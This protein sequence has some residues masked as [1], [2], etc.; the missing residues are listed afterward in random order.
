MALLKP[1]V[2]FWVLPCACQNPNF[3]SIWWLC[4]GT[5]KGPFSKN[6][7]SQRQCAFCFT[8]RTEIVFAYFSKKCH[9]NKKTLFFKTTQKHYF[10]FFPFFHFFSFALSNIKKTKTKNAFFEPPFWHLDN[11]QNISSCFHRL[12]KNTIKLGNKSWTDFWLYNIYI[13]IYAVVLL[14]GPSLLCYKTLFVKKHYK[15]GVSTL[16]FEKWRS[17]IW[18]AIVW[19]KLAIFKLQQTWPR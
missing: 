8:F 3:C 6:R 16:R 18:G 12:P 7:L 10:Q 1:K 14:S 19:A 4:M 11:L 2:P 17:Q 5:K 9:S 15:I 13:Y